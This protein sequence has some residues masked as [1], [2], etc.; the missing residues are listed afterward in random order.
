[1]KQS[2]LRVATLA[3]IAFAAGFAVARAPV[4][5]RAQASPVPAP[6]VAMSPTFV[7][8]V[9]KL[10]TQPAPPCFPNAR[11]A[12]ISKSPIATVQYAVG[13]LPA[14]YHTT[15]NEIQY[16]IAG[17]GTEQFGSTTV[18]LQPGSLLVIPPRTVHSG[19]KPV[20]NTN[21]KLLVIKVPEQ[22]AT[23]DDNFI[24]TPPPSHC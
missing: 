4:T 3:G 23:P 24:G 7:P 5:V 17:S 10:A 19:M 13:T 20:L 11:V 6:V 21:L 16:V 1:M 12:T 9:K 8:D 18:T 2:T 14:H 22:R 15:A